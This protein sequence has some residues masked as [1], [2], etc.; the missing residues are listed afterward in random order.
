MRQI[1]S[2]EDNHIYMC[3]C[4]ELRAA[5][6]SAW[7]LI[8]RH[9]GIL[10]W[11]VCTPSCNLKVSCHT[12]TLLLLSAEKSCSRLLHGWSSMD[13]AGAVSSALQCSL[14]M[15]AS[16]WPVTVLRCSCTTQ[17]VKNGASA[18]SN[19][20]AYCSLIRPCAITGHVL[21]G[22]F[23]VEDKQSQTHLI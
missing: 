10:S 13:V 18:S 5:A 17:I 7:R 1:K 21:Q 15:P 20:G 6:G 22:H 8:V 19:L 16:R 12:V 11:D 2:R 4:C 3:C 9:A 14:V 23:A